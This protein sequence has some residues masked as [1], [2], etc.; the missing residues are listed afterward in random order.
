MIAIHHQVKFLD[1]LL[2][3]HNL[4]D[5]YSSDLDI[6]QFVAKS[7]YVDLLEENDI[8]RSLI[9]LN[10]LSYRVPAIIFKSDEMDSEA[11]EKNI[12]GLL[13]S[14]PKLTN[15]KVTPKNVQIEYI[16]EESP[17]NHFTSELSF[18]LEDFKSS[19]KMELQRYGSTPTNALVYIPRII[20]CYLELKRE[21]YELVTIED[22]DNFYFMVLS[23]EFIKDFQKGPASLMIH[24]QE[25][26]KKGYLEN[27]EAL[28]SD[29]IEELAKV[30]PVE[31]KKKRAGF[32]VDHYVINKLIVF[33]IWLLVII[34]V[35]IYW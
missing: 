24:T 19:I 5:T 17:E 22:G 30:K 16:D 29:V 31:V 3:K 25:R 20:S 26:N 33:G 8:Y 12:K 28:M 10:W 21:P 4:V 32:F 9:C 2:Y 13:N 27:N 11:G 23:Q 34:G 7:G 14:L 18:E 6:E 15:N 35:I 1:N